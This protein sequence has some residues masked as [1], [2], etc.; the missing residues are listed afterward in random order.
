MPRT[1]LWLMAAGAVVTAA[2]LGEAWRGEPG[3]PAILVQAAKATASSPAAP[4][5]SPPVDAATP[6]TAAPPSVPPPTVVMASFD[7]ALIGPDGRGVIAGRAQ[8]GARIILLDGDKE[9]AQDQADANGEWVIVVQDP[10]LS[11]GPHELRVIQHVDG[12]APVTSD[13]VVVAIVPDQ[14]QSSPQKKTL[15]MIAPSSGAATLMQPPSA[16]GVPKSGDLVMSTLDYDEGGHI[17]VTGKATPGAV[18]RAYIN[19]KMVAEGQ[20][21]ADGSWRLVP[22]KPVE[23]GKYKLRL[24]RLAKDG[25]PVA[26]LEL[27]FERIPVPPATGNSER[28]VVV[29]GDSLWNIARAH[30]GT[31]FQHTLIYGANKDQIRDPDLIYPGQVFNLP[32]VN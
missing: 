30:Y 12:L 25:K 27:P 24:D 28:L 9:L 5:P 14:K 26:R 31:G 11:G 17:T 8:P 20:A 15:V 22:A 21:A 18:V 29:R 7:I 6:Q 16:A 23:P 3:E 10:P 19:D 32:K 2:V 4:A 13:Q 1:V